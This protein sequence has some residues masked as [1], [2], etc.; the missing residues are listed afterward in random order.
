MS[1]A[2]V[3]NKQLSSEVVNPFAEELAIF[4]DG[5]NL[6]AIGLDTETDLGNFINVGFATYRFFEL[7]ENRAIAVC[8][9]GTNFKIFDIDNQTQ[10]FASITLD[11]Y[12]TKVLEYGSLLII[13]GNFTN[14]LKII[15]LNTMLEISG[16][17]SLDGIVWD[18]SITSDGR[19]CLFGN[20][21]NRIKVI[22]VNT[23]QEISGF[24]TYTFDAYFNYTSSS[25]RVSYCQV[26]NG[27]E[28]VIN[29]Q[30]SSDSDVYM[31][32]IN[33]ET[34]TEVRSHSK[35]ESGSHS[36]SYLFFD[37]V[38]WLHCS[39]NI[40][41]NQKR[42]HNAVSG[43]IGQT[44]IDTSSALGINAFVNKL[45]TNYYFIR[46]HTNELM[47]YDYSNNAKLTS[48]TLGKSYSTVAWTIVTD[49][50]KP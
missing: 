29:Y 41:S 35:A 13:C 40:S 14:Y 11:N 24:P 9:S 17:P 31:K 18:A 36:N 7:K 38:G 33:L 5:N 34:K 1:Y 30:D 28:F 8:G 45:R 27:N 10:K 23:K 50:L 25:T 3:N 6:R 4:R 22:D 20:F 43:G 12:S 49:L 16:F 39:N 46:Q 44:T 19:L 48:V 47:K 2:K 37:G 32:A 26:V 15:D 21:T 42:F